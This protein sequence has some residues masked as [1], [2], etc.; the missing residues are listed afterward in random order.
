MIKCSHFTKLDMLSMIFLSSF[1][2]DGQLS[3]NYKIF[4]K[5]SE[6]FYGTEIILSLDHSFRHG[7]R[8]CDLELFK[9]D[10]RIQTDRRYGTV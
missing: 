2:M 6:G 1:P 7:F 10:F 4:K 3:E 9:P 8:N 5:E